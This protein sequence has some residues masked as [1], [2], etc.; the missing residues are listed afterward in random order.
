MDTTLPELVRD[1]RLEATFH[2]SPSTPIETTHEIRLSRRVLHSETWIR[3]RRLGNGGYGTVWLERRSEMGSRASPQLRAVKELKVP[4][5]Q[6]GRD[7]YIRE[8]EA[9]AKFS[10]RRFARFFVRFYGW[11]EASDTLFIAMKYYKHGDLKNYITKNGRLPE[12]QAQEITSQVLQG[13]LFMH[14]NNFT[15]RDLK[16]ANILIKTKPP[17]CDWQ[18]KICDLGLSK[19]I[20]GDMDSTTVKGSFGFMPPEL[21]GIGGN[22]RN[23]DSFAVDLWCLGETTFQILTGQGSFDNQ[24]K[25]MEYANGASQF[26]CATLEN[27]SVSKSAIEFVK[28]LMAATPA[29]RLTA[30]Q[31]NEHHWIAGDADIPDGA[32]SSRNIRP[33]MIDYQSTTLPLY[34]SESDEASGAWTETDTLQPP[35][36]KPQVMDRP[37]TKTSRHARTQRRRNMSQ[38]L[39]AKPVEMYEDSDKDEPLGQRVKFEPMVE[40]KYYDMDRP[41]RSPTRGG[42]HGVTEMPVPVRPTTR[43]D[44][45]VPPP[46][47]SP[48]DYYNPPPF[49]PSRPYGERSPR[50]YYYNTKPMNAQ[51]RRSNASDSRPSGFEFTSAE[52][53]F[54]EFMRGTASTED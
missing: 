52:Q 42:Y 36:F 29:G 41:I 27:F 18:V 14:D 24:A 30:K 2:P 6:G 7:G 15:H 48:R 40:M 51:H 4:R 11:F 47:P 31:A 49:T 39:E 19:R 54:A 44:H 37:P 46:P 23:A 1:S 26:P 53:I 10:K 50:Y 45:P 5:T 43:V 21:L 22:P 35:I 9:L 32:S 3:E 13:L 34:Q 38:R 8:L 33:L 17:A 28:L 20:G 16:P 12:E 25:M